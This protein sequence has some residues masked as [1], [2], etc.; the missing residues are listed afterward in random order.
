MKT[1][2]FALLVLSA[3]I[4]SNLLYSQYIQQG[5]KL[6]GVGAAEN[7]Y[8]GTSVAISS[9]GNTAVIGGC[10]NNVM[11]GAV[12]VFTRSGG[13]WSQQGHKLVGTGAAGICYQGNSVAIS[14]DGNTI[15][16]GGYYDSGRVGAIWVFNR[17]GVAWIQQGNKMVGTGGAGLPMQ[18][19]SVAIS[20]D[21]NTIIEGG[22]EDYNSKGAAWIFTRSDDIWTQQGNKLI[23]NGFADWHVLEGWSVAVSSDGNTAIIGGPGDDNSTGAIWVFNR[24]GV[25]WTQQGAKVVGAGAVGKGWQGSSVAVSSDGN[26]FVEGAPQDRGGDGSGPGAIWIFGRSAGVWMQQGTKLVGT[27]AV[28]SACQGSSVGITSDG[29]NVIEGGDWDKDY[30]GAVWIF[31]RIGGVWIQSGSKLIG[32]STVGTSYQGYSAA[33]SSDGSTLLEGGNHDNNCTGAA[34]VFYNPTI[35]ITPISN[36]VPNSFSLSQNYPN[37]F[38]PTTT[39][40][41]DVAPPLRTNGA[42]L[43]L[44]GGDVTAAAGTVGVKLKVYDILGKEIITLV[45]Q[46]LQPGTYEVTFDGT[47][48]PSGI[49]FYRL[50]S[51]SFVETK[52]MLM[53]K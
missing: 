27:G 29:N 47:N 40:R 10:Q 5:P 38:N 31:N 43:P 13:I 24:S 17:K 22:P 3:I 1:K 18:G 49:Y 11:T 35:G 20:A 30:N 4:F 37:P 33:I 23:G 6:V 7:S 34:W 12:W 9:D 51:G 45:N 39:I 42:H 52:K 19:W 50:E 41:I 21:G 48:L 25:T 14:S 28:G 53:V 2:L 44:S 16:E 32:D 15:V 8:Q 26:T 46:Q 36:Q